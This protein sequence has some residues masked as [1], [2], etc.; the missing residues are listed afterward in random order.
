MRSTII[1]LLLFSSLFLQNLYA[2]EAKRAYTFSEL[3]KKGKML[4]V[5]IRSAEVAREG[6]GPLKDFFRLGDHLKAELKDGSLGTG[7]IIDPAG[8]VLTAYHVIAPQ[9]RNRVAKEI[10]V[11]LPDGRELPADVIGKDRKLD[12][13]LLRIEE[14]EGFHAAVLG[15]S[16]GLEIGEWVMTVGNAFGIE[17]AVTVG[18]VSGTGRVLGAGPYDHFIQTD[19]AIHAGN[20]G[21]PL[22]NI[23]GEV[24]GMN[25]AVSASGQG[26]GF[27]TPINMIKKILT[28]LEKDG[29]V[30]R[31]WL[32]VMIQS[33]TRDLARAFQL[34]DDSGALVSEVMKKSPAEEAGVLRGDVIMKFDG[35]PVGKMHDLPSLVAET[36]V[37]KAVSLD[38]IRDGAPL[39][40]RVK[41]SLLKEDSE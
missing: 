6:G 11:R 25:A 1:S 33:L 28:S 12:V 23:Y 32:G 18:V 21:G 4:V 41:I 36:P 27:A 19:A 31:G 17:E 3:A 39:T 15:D 35:K 14:G 40:L 7:F 13:A 29:K 9:P 26:I 22:L 16:A 20:S 10:T 24:I 38:L 30:T 34:K 8:L 37:G 5:N 2:E